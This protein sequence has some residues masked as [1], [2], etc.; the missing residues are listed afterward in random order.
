MT[1]PGSGAS[2]FGCSPPMPE[3]GPPRLCLRMLA[4][5]TER[6]SVIYFGSN[7]RQ[8]SLENS[9]ALTA[10]I[11][12]AGV[13]NTSVYIVDAALVPEAGDRDSFL[14]LATETGG[15]ALLDGGDLSSKIVEVEQAASSYYVI[16]Y[17]S[18]DPK[19]DGSFRHID[20]SL[21]DGAGTL[22]FRR[23]YY[24]EGLY[25]RRSGD[26]EQ[27]LR[28]VLGWGIPPT[29]IVLQGEIDSFSVDPKSSRVDV[30]I[31]MPGRERLLARKTGIERTSYDVLGR[32]THDGREVKSLRDSLELDLNRSL[33]EELS[34]DPIVY[35][36]SFTLAPG[37]YELRLLVMNHD[38]RRATVYQTEFTAVAPRAKPGQ[39]PISSVV[40][41]NPKATQM[42][43]VTHVFRRRDGMR[44]YFEIYEPSSK[45]A[46]QLT[47]TIT[48][49]RGAK[50]AFE[51]LAIHP[52]APPEPQSYPVPMRFQIPISSL[53]TGEYRCQITVADPGGKR[54]THWEASV[55]I[56][57]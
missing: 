38:S 9:S 3:W 30:T 4:S 53:A 31:W 14:R 35:R 1:F 57:N 29:D 16:G 8:K 24:T 48:L 18:T 27:A 10:A 37:S 42:P 43:N 52:T 40:L 21:K 17:Y 50:K 33:D 23:G 7:L 25:P 6:K 5:I 36:A 44:G 45:V 28:S 34:R 55:L 56:A 13:I 19:L 41:I 12:S 54:S 39:I 22:G 20:I 2:R 15:R 51:I 49:Y 11:R 46:S 47:V 32:V 26:T